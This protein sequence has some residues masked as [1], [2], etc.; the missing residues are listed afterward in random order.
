MVVALIGFGFGLG[1]IASWFFAVRPLVH[2]V[3]DMRYQGFIH[4][5]P[6]PKPKLMPEMVTR[7]ET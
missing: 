6:P 7:N 5:R 1:W 3:R 4:D 2:N